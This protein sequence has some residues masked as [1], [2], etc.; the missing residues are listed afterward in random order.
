MDPATRYLNQLEAAQEQLLVFARELNLLYQSERTRAGELE[1]ALR[2]REES[3]LDMVKTL[4]FVVEAKDPTT[5]AHLDRT[6]DYATALAQVVDAELASDAC[7]RYGF[8]LHD[9]GKVGVPEAILNKPGPLD[10]NEWLVMRTHPEMGVQM[11]SGIKSL[12]PAVEVI[13]SHHE[14]WDGGGYP[15][16]LMGEE[17][18][19][20]ARI[21]SVC[22][23]FDA[24]TSDRPYRRA[25]P[26]ERAVEQIVAGTGT[27]F[28]PAMADAFVSITDLEALHAS[29]HTRIAPDATRERILAR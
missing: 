23:A 19:L 12:G 2:R 28:D 5:R 9:V 3:Y 13:R 6:H 8:L 11:V 1:E 17:I 25:L 18:P 10:E 29:L 7:L 20:S 22:D 24:M 14:R 16:G 27:Q 4:A 15:S 26:F 21:F